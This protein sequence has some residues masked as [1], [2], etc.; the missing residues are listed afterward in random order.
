M[1]VP[2]AY[3]RYT[4]PENNGEV[5][6]WPTANQILSDFRTNLDRFAQSN[7]QILHR[8][9]RDWRNIARQDMMKASRLYHKT[10]NL[11]IPNYPSKAPL[12]V[13]GH[14]PGFFH[15][16]ILAKY[17]LLDSLARSTGAVALNLVADSD[18]PRNT[19]L[20]IPTRH[21][22]GFVI[23]EIPFPSIDPSIPLEYQTAPNPAEF[24]NFLETLRKLRVEESMEA[25]IR[26]IVHVLEE[27]Y[28]QASMA[29]DI[30]V[31]LHQRY[32]EN[33]ALQW[34]DVPVWQ[35]AQSEAFLIFA[36]DMIVRAAEVR[37]W[38][39]TSLRQYRR[40]HKIR[41]ASQP[42]PELHGSQNPAEAQELPFWAIPPGQ[43]RQPLW[44]RSDQ[45]ELALQAGNT[46]FAVLPGDRL[47]DPDS[48]GRELHDLLDRTRFHI[49][50]RAV[51]LTTFARLFLADYFVHG[52]G[53][54]RYDHV[55]DEFIRNF[56]SMEPPSFATATATVLLPM[57]RTPDRSEAMEHIRNL[58][59]KWR[60]LHYNPQRYMAEGTDRLSGSESKKLEKLLIERA[61][62]IH[63]S[64][65]LRR[66]RADSRDR[67]K[68]FDTIH[69]CNADILAKIPAVKQGLSRQLAQA[70]SR[71]Q[72]AEMARD[73]EYF[74][75]LIPNESWKQL[76]H[77]PA[78]RF[79]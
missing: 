71:L 74:F 63:T 60:D 43:P 9:L 16:G 73:R 4:T 20:K 23:Q 45:S 27:A 51:A 18:V 50:P 38:Y 7:I 25:S 59:M 10:L 66:D 2:A 37:H 79:P 6:L 12:L 72:Q 54:A 56:Y 35:M 65:Q 70:E 40:I 34:F 46:T 36:A 17:L 13:T 8:P 26:H 78:L 32:A 76:Q 52:I 77:N 19:T 1:D 68:I 57:G 15:G 28:S 39:N 75:G 31:L 62:A 44:I 49:R 47:T 3:P 69:Q 42:L 22:E 29:T 41:N 24:H 21:D 53:G 30:F 14:Q 11:P 67:R 61:E 64:D 48:T 55:T 58:R 33:M 5:F